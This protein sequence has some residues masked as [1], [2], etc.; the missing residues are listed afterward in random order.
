MQQVLLWDRFLNF[1]DIRVFYKHTKAQISK[2]LNMFQEY[3]WASFLY[4]LWKL[5]DCPNGC[6][7]LVTLAI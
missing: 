2:M 3:S 1:L 4:Q 6:P 7:K 5:I